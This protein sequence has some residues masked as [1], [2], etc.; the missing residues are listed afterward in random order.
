MRLFAFHIILI[1]L[2]KGVTL[3][4]FSFQLWLKSRIDWLFSLCIA[5]GWGKEKI[6]LKSVKLH[7]KIDLVLHPTCTDD[8][9]GNKDFGLVSFLHINSKASFVEEVMI[10]S[11]GDKGVHAFSQDIN[12]RVSIIARM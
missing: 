10:H 4:L 8:G 9:D 7:L 11:W 1:H 5:T 12:Q 3:S 2:G 6:E